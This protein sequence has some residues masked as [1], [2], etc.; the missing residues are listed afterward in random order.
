MVSS[1]LFC[2]GAGIKCL[3]LVA[4]LKRRKKITFKTFKMKTI[5]VIFMKDTVDYH[6]GMWGC[7]SGR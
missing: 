1:V 3:A 4:G 6:F 7:F 2:V 5:R